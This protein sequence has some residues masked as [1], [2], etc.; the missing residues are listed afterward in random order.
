M[1]TLTIAFCDYFTDEHNTLM[2]ALVER[3]D[4]V[5][6]LSKTNGLWVVMADVICT[7]ILYQLS[8]IEAFIVGEGY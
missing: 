4:G 3:L 1:N 8:N 5:K 6:V 7:P 2:Q